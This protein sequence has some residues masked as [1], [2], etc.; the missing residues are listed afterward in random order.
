MELDLGLAP[1]EDYNGESLDDR[2]FDLCK[3][4]QHLIHTFQKFHSPLLSYVE[5]GWINAI[6]GKFRA[7]WKKIIELVTTMEIAENEK[8]MII[9]NNKEDKDEMSEKEN[10]HPNDAKY[11]TVYVHYVEKDVQIFSH[12]YRYGF[13][14]L[15]AHNR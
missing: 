15:N 14:G 5:D 12:M 9:N 6:D 4:F 13:V 10:N 1:A 3:D 8:N 7:N 11:S 2:I